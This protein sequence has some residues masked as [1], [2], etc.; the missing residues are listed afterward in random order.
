MKSGRASLTGNFLVAAL[1]I[2]VFVGTGCKSHNQ[3][4]A[5][6]LPPASSSLYPSSTNYTAPEDGNAIWAANDVEP[7]QAVPSKPK[8]K[9]F[10][11]RSGE[12]LASYKVQKGDNLSKIA[13]RYGTS[14]SRIQSANGLTSTKILAGKTYK[15]PTKKSADEIASVNSS[16]TARIQ[17]APS[18]PTPPSPPTTTSYNPSATT[19]SSSPSRTQSYKPATSNNSY[20]AVSDAYKNY[21]ASQTRSYAPT[22]STASRPTF[23]PRNFNTSNYSGPQISTPSSSNSIT[24]PTEEASGNSGSAFPAPTFNSNYR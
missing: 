21:N 14:V 11:L 2:P 12:T 10:S 24:V 19:I 13:S 9:P 17:M 7:V 15:V 6:N 1:A 8:P 4:T 16:T 23:T 22:T 5:A 20:K 3:D 18:K